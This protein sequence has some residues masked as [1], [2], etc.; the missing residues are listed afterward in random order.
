MAA[1][2]DNRSVV[3]KAP[4]DIPTESKH[5]ARMLGSMLMGH[6][7]TVAKPADKMLYYKLQH[8]FAI[9]LDLIEAEEKKAQIA[10]DMLIGASV[11]SLTQSVNAAKKTITAASFDDGE[12]YF[13]EQKVIRVN[14]VNTEW[15]WTWVRSQ[16]KRKISLEVVSKIM[17]TSPKIFFTIISYFTGLQPDAPMRA[18]W[19]KKVDYAKVLT[20]L[21]DDRGQPMNQGQ[22][23][24]HQALNDKGLPVF[25]APFCT[26]ALKPNP[27]DDT[28][29]G[30]IQYNFGKKEQVA[31]PPKEKFDIDTT[32]QC[33]F[34]VFQAHIEVLGKKIFLRDSMKK[35]GLPAFE[36]KKLVGILEEDMTRIT[37]MVSMGKGDGAVQPDEELRQANK[38]A[39]RSA[40]SGRPKALQGQ[41][42][43]DERALADLTAGEMAD[44]PNIPSDQ[45]ESAGA[46]SAAD[47]P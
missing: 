15:M 29:A 11:L 41:G 5:A 3:Q 6:P 42:D 39:R 1:S 17:V 34:D 24:F 40:P 14:L 4:L 45:P 31:I 18:A 37:M 12:P 10:K 38:R 28:K 25:A 35:Y 33:N 30:F 26:F 32:I 27:T 19:L 47:R 44:A 9:S 20:M 16:Y 36:R 46:S 2:A 13:N 22:G 43:D 8:V 7:I 23:F 21:H